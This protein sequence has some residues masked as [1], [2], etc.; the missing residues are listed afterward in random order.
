MMRPV[1]RKFSSDSGGVT[2][3]APTHPGTPGG[4]ATPTTPTP[5]GRTTP[6]APPTPGSFRPRHLG[7][8]GCAGVVYHGCRGSIRS[9]RSIKMFRMSMF[10]FVQVLFKHQFVMW[11]SPRVDNQCAGHDAKKSSNFR[12]SLGR[13]QALLWEWNV[14]NEC[15]G[16]TTA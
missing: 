8:L 1:P 6:T 9:I 10:K 4:R 15:A 3:T 12:K 11:F 5:G 2:P 14:H 7:T 13:R 16:G